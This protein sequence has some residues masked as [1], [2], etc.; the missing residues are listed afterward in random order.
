MIVGLINTCIIKTVIVADVLAGDSGDNETSE[1]THTDTTCGH[2]L[3][4][5]VQ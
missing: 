3:N 4:K 2:D 1:G 5:V